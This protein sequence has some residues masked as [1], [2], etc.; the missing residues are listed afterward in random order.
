MKFFKK[1]ICF[2]LICASLLLAGTVY[3][4][5]NVVECTEID[6]SC[7]HQGLQLSTLLE[8]QSISFSLIALA[9]LLDGINPCAIGMLILLLGYLMVFAHQPKRMVKLGLIYIITVFITYFLIGLV[10]SQIISQLLA[11]PLYDQ[12]SL[13]IKW[14]IVI[15]IWI[16]A[17]INIKDVFWY[18]KGF[19][20][21]VTKA[22]VPILMK[23]IKKVDVSATIILGVV[24]TI[25]ELPCSLPLY[26]GSIAIMAEAFSQFATVFYLLLYD[27]MFV[28]P[29][30]VVFAVLVKT[31][32]IFEVKDIQERANK[33][34][35]LSMAIAQ[36]LIGVGLLLI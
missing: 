22:E 2:I 21:G 19:S 10:F 12:V 14:I 16:A 11:W 35:K 23:L 13:V 15:F 33:W 25:F 28:V 32:H 1:I 27:F 20:L 4:E 30:I 36:I 7:S 31:H 34:M 8:N 9:G 29:L 3:A 5:Q 17:L 6:N 26:L 18:G 24:V